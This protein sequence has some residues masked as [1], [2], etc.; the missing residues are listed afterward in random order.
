MVNDNGAIADTVQY[1]IAA[2]NDGADV[3]VV[4]NTAKDNV[5]L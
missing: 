2:E 1:A 4:T 3:I 5:S